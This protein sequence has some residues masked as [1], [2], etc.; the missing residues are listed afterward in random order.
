MVDGCNC[1]CPVRCCF[2][3]LFF[4]K[5]GKL[6]RLC[7]YAPFFGEKDAELF[8]AIMGANFEFDSPYWDNISKSGKQRGAGINQ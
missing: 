8:A 2:V 3:A 7:G 4:L 5:K 1:L 6:C